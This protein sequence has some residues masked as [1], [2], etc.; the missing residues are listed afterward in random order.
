MQYP[1]PWIMWFIAYLTPHYNAM[2]KHLRGYKTRNIILYYISSVNYSDRAKI[3]KS[4]R[5]KTWPRDWSFPQS[6]DCDNIHN[7]RRFLTV[8]WKEFHKSEDLRTTFPDPALIAFKQNTSLNNKL[9]LA[10]HPDTESNTDTVRTPRRTTRSTNT[11]PDT[12]SNT[13]TVRTPRRTTRSTNTH[14][15]TES[16]TDMVRTP[17]RMTRSTNTHPDTESNTD[18]VRTPRRM[19]RSTNAHPDTESNTEAKWK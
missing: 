17:R 16:N 7:L 12:E 2:T 9:V 10:R 4:K 11:H 19:T 14:P 6:T 5:I 15:D 3:N 8:C 1:S 13:D 18:T